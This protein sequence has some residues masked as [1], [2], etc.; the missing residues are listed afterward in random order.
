MSSVA[1]LR[2]ITPT[3]DQGESGC[4]VF[5]RELSI[6]HYFS[7]F[8]GIVTMERRWFLAP[9]TAAV[10]ATGL[11]ILSA[12]SKHWTENSAAGGRVAGYLGLWKGCF[13]YLGTWVCGDI[14]WL[15]SGILICFVAF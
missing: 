6:V 15:H 10:V 1:V 11:S 5:N 3:D 7:I 8:L 9:S 14:T 4:V 13:K 12:S 2:Y